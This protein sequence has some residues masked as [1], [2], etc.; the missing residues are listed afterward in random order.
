MSWRMAIAS[1]LRSRGFW[2]WQVAGAVIY[3]IPAAIRFATG[4][5]YLPVLSW[6]ATPW[7][8]HYVPGNVV[9]K[10][11]VQAFFPGGAGAVAGEVLVVNRDGKALAGRRK[12]VARL[13]GALSWASAWCLVLL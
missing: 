7:I 3:G 8:D 11:L 12:Y 10:V 2:G 4:S 6:F 1:T 9:E 13:A 5:V